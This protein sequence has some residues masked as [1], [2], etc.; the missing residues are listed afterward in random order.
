MKSNNKIFC[1]GLNKTGTSSLHEAFQILGYK[2]VHYIESGGKSIKDIIKTNFDNGLN[3]LTGIEQ[4][5]AYTDW[6]HPSTNILF[7]EF[8]KQFPNSKFIL[9]TRDVDAWIK[10]REKHLNRTP[11][12]KKKQKQNP[13]NK[14]LKMDKALWREEFNLHH[15]NVRKYF[16]DRPKDLLEFDVTIGDG[17]EKICHFLNKET[18]NIEFPIANR[19]SDQSRRYKYYEKIKRLIKKIIYVKIRS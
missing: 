1:I 15:K 9:N 2:S 10:S 12:L 18:P 8:D 6:S 17:W 7:K 3:I 19:A 16:E 14:W 11:N 4:Y 13:N 5:D